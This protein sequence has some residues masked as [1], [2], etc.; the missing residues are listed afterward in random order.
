VPPDRD[1]NLPRRIAARARRLNRDPRLVELARGR[2]LRAMGEEP[3]EPS[4]G[5][6]GHP[7]DHAVR[8]LA[9]IR[10]DRPGVLGELGMTALQAWQRLAESQA[11][12]RGD[13]DVVILFTD[14]VGFSSWALDAGDRAALRLLNEVAAAIE[15]PVAERRG[16]VVKRLGDGL[17]AAFGDGPDAFEAALAMDDR[18]TTL[19]V[20]GYRPQLRTGIHLG[21]PRKLRGDYFGIDVNVAA[22]LVEAA[23]PGEIL[24]S[25][26]VV[27]TLPSDAVEAKRRRFSAKGAPKD[28]AVYSLESSTVAN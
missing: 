12:G 26:A 9:A 17:M 15:P 19:E 3:A 7:A 10:G 25:Q 23:K 20:D 18:V 24:A 21:R 4:P 14:L 8:H 22:R 16:E 11:R 2:R 28:L 27:E 5:S 1:E 13:V 6:G